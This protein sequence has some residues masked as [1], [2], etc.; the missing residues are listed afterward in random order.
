ML[1]SVS[2]S[3]K[4]LRTLPDVRSV[5]TRKP[6]VDMHRQAMTDTVVETCVTRAKRSSVGV[7]SEP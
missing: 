7:R 4:L 5:K 2:S 6:D 1:M 3:L